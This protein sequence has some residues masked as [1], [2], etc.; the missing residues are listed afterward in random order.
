MPAIARITRVVPVAAAI[1]F[2]AFV[3]AKGFPTL[4]HDWNWP[5][6]RIAIPSFF[7]ESVNGWLSNGFGLANAHPTTYLLALPVVAAMWLLGPLAALA[8]LALA[9]GYCCMRVRRGVASGWRYGD[10]RQWASDSS[11]SSTL[12]F[13]TKSS[14]D[15]L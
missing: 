6:D 10:R 1:L 3:V 8:L 4:R 5:I 13:T 2:A 11:R 7:D 14:P 15:I 12:G 9:S